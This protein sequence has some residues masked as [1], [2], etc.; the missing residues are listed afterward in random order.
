MAA[1]IRPSVTPPSAD[2]TTAGV[3]DESPTAVCA[4]E[5]N[6]PN[7]FN[8]ATTIAFTLEREESFAL[9]VYDLAG[10][11]VRTLAGGA[12]GPG[13]WL[14]EWDGRDARDEPA[15][16]GTYLYRLTA[17]DRTETRKMALVR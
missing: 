9:G 4:L 6:F 8:P 3:G 13:R 15:P 14:A 12:R 1:A 17:G 16:S 5:P 2:T 10:R 7:P 11:L